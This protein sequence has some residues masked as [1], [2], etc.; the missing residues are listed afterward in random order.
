MRTAAEESGPQDYKFSSTPS[1]S[2]GNLSR[3]PTHSS[4]SNQREQHDDWKSNKSWNFWR[5][6]SWTEQWWFLSSEMLFFFR[7]PESEFPGNRREVYLSARHIFTRAVTHQNTQHRRHVYNGSRDFFCA[8]KGPSSTRHGSYF[9][10]LLSSSSPNPD[11][12]STYPIILCEGPRQDGTST[13]C[14]SSTQV[15]SLFLSSTDARSTWMS[16]EN[17]PRLMTHSLIFSSFGV[18]TSANEGWRQCRTMAGLAAPGGQHPP[19]A[20]WRESSTSHS[21]SLVGHSVQRHETL[22]PIAVGTRDHKW[23]WG[24]R[25][26]HQTTAPE[27]LR[28]WAPWLKRT[29]PQVMSPTTTSS[30]RLMSSIPRSPW[31]NRIDVHTHCMAQ[32]CTPFLWRPC[33]KLSLFLMRRQWLIPAFHH[34]RNYLSSKP[35]TPRPD[36]MLLTHDKSVQ[37]TRCNYQGSHLLFHLSHGVPHHT[38]RRRTLF[39]WSL[40]NSSV[41]KAL[42]QFCYNCITKCSHW[43][44]IDWSYGWLDCLFDCRLVALYRIIMLGFA[45][46]TKNGVDPLVSPLKAC[47]CPSAKNP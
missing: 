47:S 25:P 13:E 39:W 3:N 31:P 19:D 34:P 4:S 26:R 30:R 35:Q 37:L 7:L 15:F 14:P 22:P 38:S 24:H 33:E 40:C 41:T 21:E 46:T 29:P 45:F 36:D 11:L 42:F 2:W 23:L 12:L 28:S 32:V 44:F 6:S 43:K 16:Q 5:S 1:K 18:Q 27:T 9:P 20:R 10:V 8:K 17:D